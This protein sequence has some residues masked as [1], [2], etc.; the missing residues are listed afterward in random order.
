MDV[1]QQYRDEVLN[2]KV[3][4]DVIKR[5]NQPERHILVSYKVYAVLIARLE[6]LEQ[7]VAGQHFGAKPAQVVPAIAP[8]PGEP[9]G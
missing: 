3:E 7:R 9:Q 4:P 2:P 1:L 8:R 6:A 5:L